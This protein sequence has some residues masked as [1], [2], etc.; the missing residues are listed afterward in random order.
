MSGRLSEQQSVSVNG[1]VCIPT[2]LSYI[3]HIEITSCLSHD[4]LQYICVRGVKQLES[5]FYMNG[6]FKQEQVLP[7]FKKFSVVFHPPPRFY[8]THIT[9][10]SI[11]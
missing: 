8:S 1:L 2:C 5:Y 4:K 6:K 3:F 11:T 7:K 10:T 9:G